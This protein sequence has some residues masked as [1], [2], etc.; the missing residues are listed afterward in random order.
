MTAF[1][2]IQAVLRKQFSPA[3]WASPVP[4][5]L[6]PKPPRLRLFKNLSFG[7]PSSEQFCRF[8]LI[9]GQI[10]QSEIQSPRFS[11]MTDS[12]PSPL[13]QEPIPAVMRQLLEACQLAATSRKDSWQFAVEITTLTHL[14]VSYSQIRW[15]I[16]EGLVEAQVETTNAAT[17]RRTYRKLHSLALPERTCLVL[18]DRGQQAAAQVQHEPNRPPIDGASEANSNNLRASDRPRWDAQ[19]RQLRFKGQLVKA[20][21]VPAPKQEA[22]LAAFERAGWPHCIADPLDEAREQPPKQRLPNTIRALNRC[23]SRPSLR[24]HGDGTGSRIC[25]AVTSKRSRAVVPESNQD[26]TLSDQQPGS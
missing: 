19:R 12:V 21:R 11:A 26:R 24:F 18:T 2:L 17:R 22:I 16:A 9:A 5:N 23:Q 15:L 8:E 7:L 14:K 4:T 13:D 25:W 6:R 3:V 1:Q 10:R 20:Y